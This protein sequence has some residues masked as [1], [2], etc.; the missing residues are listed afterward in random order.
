MAQ[1]DFRQLD[2]DA[3]GD[4]LPQNRHF[5]G[6]SIALTLQGEIPKVFPCQE[7]FV[8]MPLQTIKIERQVEAIPTGEWG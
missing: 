3:G 1:P 5:G 8:D 4:S 6:Q 7:Q 2:T